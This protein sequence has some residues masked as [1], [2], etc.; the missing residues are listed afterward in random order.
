MPNGLRQRGQYPTRRRRTAWRWRRT[1]ANVHLTVLW[2]E[3]RPNNKESGENL[4]ALYTVVATC[5]AN[6]VDPLAYLT[7]VLTRLDSTP[8]DQVDTLLPQN[9]AG[10]AP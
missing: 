6:E 4:T 9:W 5:V 7:D 1:I 2:G 3:K 10:L 8:A